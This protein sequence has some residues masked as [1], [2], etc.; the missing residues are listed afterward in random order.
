MSARVIS[1]GGAGGVSGKGA[2]DPRPTVLD[3]SY[4][5]TQIYIITARRASRH[6]TITHAVCA[7]RIMIRTLLLA[8]CC[9]Y[10]YYAMRCA[11]KQDVVVDW[12]C[13]QNE[14]AGADL[15]GD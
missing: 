11:G 12:T 7:V 6:G 2:N 9:E 13:P 10:N 8:L 15:G 14:T 4:S 3:Q 5:A 1:R